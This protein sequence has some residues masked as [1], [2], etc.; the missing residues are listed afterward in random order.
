[1]SSTQADVLCDV[2]GRS[3]EK[4]ALSESFI[5][6]SQLSFINLSTASPRSNS[7]RASKSTKHRIAMRKTRPCLLAV[8]KLLDHSDG[9][10]SCK[11]KAKKACVTLFLSYAR[12]S[13]FRINSQT[14][15]PV[16]QSPN[17]TLE[18]LV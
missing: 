17:R 8:R 9:L 10:A 15:G 2:A 18:L 4:G 11:S 14:S 5:H 16:D 6:R 7:E 13:L 12:A 1:M 3:S